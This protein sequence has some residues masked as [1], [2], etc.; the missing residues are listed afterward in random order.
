[1]LLKENHASILFAD[2]PEIN[3]DRTQILQLFQNIIGNG[4]K[5]NEN[6]RPTVKVKCITRASEV[7]FVIADNGIGIPEA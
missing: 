1:M 4:I 5:Y 3:A 2:L 7:E 6:E